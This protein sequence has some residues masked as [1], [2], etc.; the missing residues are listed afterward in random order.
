MQRFFSQSTNIWATRGKK[1][2]TFYQK[3]K[4]VGSTK[5][6]EFKKQL[7]MFI[8]TIEFPYAETVGNMAK[9]QPIFFEFSLSITLHNSCTA[10]IT[11]VPTK[12]RQLSTTGRWIW[13]WPPWSFSG[14]E[15]HGQWSSFWERWYSR[16]FSLNSRFENLFK[17]HGEM[18][19]AVVYSLTIKEV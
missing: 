18:Y 4:L 16:K 5:K 17:P 13:R 7:Q 11:C 19:Q 1:W 10:V 15:H 14:A 6:T 2:K 8:P 12:I 3:K 9:C